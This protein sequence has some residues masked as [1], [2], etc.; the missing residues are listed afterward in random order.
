MRRKERYIKNL[1][2]TADVI[3]GFNYWY[4]KLLAFCL[5]MFEYKNLP[6][7]LSSYEIESNLILTGHCTIFESDGELI[8]N[9]SVLFGND[10]YLQ[11]TNATT[12]VINR[13]NP[14]LRINHTFKKYGQ[15]GKNAV[16]FYNSILKEYTL[17]FKT[18][19]SLNTFISR[20]ARQLADIES[21]ISIY[22]VSIRDSYIPASDDAKTKES[23]LS[24][25]KKRALGKRAIVADNSI[26]PLLKSI[27][28]S[29]GKNVK[30][31]LNDLLIARDKILESFYRDIGVKFYNPKKAQVGEAET[32]A[33]NNLL[34]INTADLYNARIK[35]IAE[36]NDMFGTNIEV[37]FSESFKRMR[38]SATENT[39]ESEVK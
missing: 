38:Q 30:D 14:T 27:D 11:P 9:E 26:V 29:S 25:Y 33:N 35:G 34:L 2:D 23:L 12:A 24:F 37:D 36:T 17:G 1:I 6:S 4:D 21:T 28:I 3:E 13:H 10:L 39:T 8:T 7:T 20:Y 19:S 31:G 5:S 22:T 16:T 15:K 18:D 32:E